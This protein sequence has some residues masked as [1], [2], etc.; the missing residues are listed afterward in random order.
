MIVAA[1][2]TFPSRTVG[3]A[4]QE[5]AVEWLRT[6]F[7]AAVQALHRRGIEPEDA[8]AI[9]RAFVDHWYS[10]VGPERDR[11]EWNFN[12]GNI[13]CAG[14]PDL[15][16]QPFGWRGDCV[17]VRSGT[18]RAYP[19]LADGVSDY[20]RLQVARYAAPLAFLWRNPEARTDWYARIL[21][22][23]YSPYTDAKVRAFATVDRAFV[24]LAHAA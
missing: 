20:V 9:A 1:E 13:A 24:R 19:T 10:E 4:S 16:G 11:A 7:L 5:D 21:R 6:R 12:V 22:A 23:G 18:Y 14:T 8:T 17:V 15:D 3:P 2:N